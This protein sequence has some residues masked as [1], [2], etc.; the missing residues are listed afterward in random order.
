VN[1][2]RALI[3]EALERCRGF[4]HRCLSNP[5]SKIPERCIRGHTPLSTAV[6][7][8]AI[9]ELIYGIMTVIHMFCWKLHA[10]VLKFYRLCGKLFNDAFL[11]KKV[12]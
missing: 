8:L 4:N 11:N 10:Q 3:G 2:I 1:R 6:Y 7:L 9:S 12:Y 5:A